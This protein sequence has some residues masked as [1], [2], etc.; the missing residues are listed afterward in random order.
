MTEGLF[1][2]P[3]KTV[4]V[5]FAKDSSDAYTA[6]PIFS[7]GS[8]WHTGRTINDRPYEQG[9]VHRESPARRFDVVVYRNFCRLSG[10]AIKPPRE[11]GLLGISGRQKSTDLVIFHKS[12]F[13]IF[14]PYYRAKVDFRYGKLCGKCGKPKHIKLFFG[15]FLHLGM[16]N[17]LKR[18][19]I[20]F[21]KIN[22][23]PRIAQ[24][25]RN[26]HM[27]PRYPCRR[28]FVSIRYTRRKP[29]KPVFCASF[30]PRLVSKRCIFFDPWITKFSFWQSGENV[31]KNKQKR[32]IL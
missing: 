19:S 6:M 9:S 2:S 22:H 24:F 27:L 7:R 23:F 3:H 17:F 8:E 11:S 25:C 30:Y 31:H 12:E 14:C 5:R 21:L 13:P 10:E 29:P 4:F 32:A 15:P 18:L 28:L 26:C 16:G 1:F 20:G